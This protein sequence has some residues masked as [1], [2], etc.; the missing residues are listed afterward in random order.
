MN[1]RKFEKFEIKKRFPKSGIFVTL[2]SLQL[3]Y[4]LLTGSKAINYK[5]QNALWF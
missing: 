5:T 2:P 3:L 4:S 1:F